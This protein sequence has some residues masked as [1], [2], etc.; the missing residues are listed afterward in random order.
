MG[1]ELELKGF[2]GYEMTVHYI[3]VGYLKKTYELIEKM[4][5]DDPLNPN[6]CGVYILALGSLGDMDRAK[7]EYERKKAI[8]GNNWFAGDVIINSLSVGTEELVSVNF[9]SQTWRGEAWSIIGANSESPQK[10]IVELRGFY[11]N[12]DNLTSVL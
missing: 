2:Y 6:T 1:L 10:G 9:P 7:E 8:F 11:N 4:R 12:G 5:R 3:G